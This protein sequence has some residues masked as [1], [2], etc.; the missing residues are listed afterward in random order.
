MFLPLV[1]YGMAAIG[2]YGGYKNVVKLQEDVGESNTVKALLKLDPTGL[3]K[4][5]PVITAQAKSLD[6][7][8]S[9]DKGAILID[10]GLI[11]IGLFI[12]TRDR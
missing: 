12:A 11:L 1:G 2:A 5:Q 6:D 9:Q 10:G 3:V 8:I 7:A 4:Q